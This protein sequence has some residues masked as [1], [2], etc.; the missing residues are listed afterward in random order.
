[1]DFDRLLGLDLVRR[2][3]C[4]KRHLRWIELVRTRD[5]FRRESSETDRRSGL[6]P[7]EGRDSEKD[8]RADA[9][10]DE[11]RSM[12]YEVRDTLTGTLVLP[13]PAWANDEGTIASSDDVESFAGRAGEVEFTVSIVA[14]QGWRN[15]SAV[16]LRC[17][18]GRAV[19][20]RRSSWSTTGSRGL[21]SASR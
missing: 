8:A 3:V 18:T 12:G 6:C 21:W 2:I 9:I 16:W 13:A 4:R 14:R 7:G 19:F 11:I 5:A 10:R 15:S 17:V 1:M 20:A